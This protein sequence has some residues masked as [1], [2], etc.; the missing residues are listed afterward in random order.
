M[1]SSRFPGKV[2]AEIEGEPMLSRVVE[3]VQRAR[4]LHQVVVATS[5]QP[6]DDAL[7]R[8]CQTNQILCFRGSQ[9]DVLDRY[10]RAAEHFD[11]EVIVRLTADC[12]LLDPV[13]I[14]KVVGVFLSGEFDYTSNV[15]EPTYPDG[16]DTEVFA[17]EALNRTWQEASL[18]SEREHVTPYIN[19][20]P[21]VFRL[22]SVRNATDLSA[23]RWT[24]DVPQD[25][26]FVRQIYRHLVSKPSFGMEDVLSILRENR[27][28]T[29]IN[30]GFS[31]NQGYAKSLAEDRS[32]IKDQS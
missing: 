9:N 20:H 11:V 28:L 7:E 30:A 10:Y 26:D 12:P 24:V 8:F 3:R 15:R 4:Q 22:G 25:L 32:V 1:G 21:D 5:D 14:D 18:P 2:L 23:L 16:L 6:G 27:E 13:I 31:R 17:R 19:K 29:A